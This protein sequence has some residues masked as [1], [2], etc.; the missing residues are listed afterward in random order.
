[1]DPA[2]NLVSCRLKRDLDDLKR[3]LEETQNELNAWKFTPD[4][5]TGK[6][7]M[8]KCRLLYQENE[9]LGK[10]VSAGRVAK[11]EGDLAL[12]KNF[13]AELKKSQSELEEFLSELDEDVEGLQ[14]TIYY[15][16]KQ[17]QETKDQVEQL[18]HDNE[19]LRRTQS[20]QP[21]AANIEELTNGPIAIDPDE[22]I[23]QGEML[24][25][26]DIPKEVEIQ[27]N[28]NIDEG[29]DEV[30]T[31]ESASEGH[32]EE[33][34]ELEEE[35]QVE[36]EEEEETR[37][38][39]SQAIEADDATMDSEE[40]TQSELVSSSRDQSS[41]A[42]ACVEYD[43]EYSQLDTEQPDSSGLKNH[44]HSNNAA[45]YGMRTRSARKRQSNNQDFSVSSS[46]NGHN[47]SNSNK[48]L[49]DGPLPPRTSKRLRYAQDEA[50]QEPDEGQSSS[51]ASLTN[52]LT[53][54][55]G[56][57]DE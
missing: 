57:I 26:E 49:V 42:A 41:H 48:R 29:E 2:V 30:Q 39:S 15:L 45:C 56:S 3:R 52:G 18:I 22:S 43:L 19:A 27:E 36:E 17:L 14:S 44:H 11:L 6:R 13:S 32:G 38:E 7:L 12:Q 46:N 8:A 16:Q 5:N 20:T 34:E 9:E 40:G 33:V 31:Q 23:E 53:Q 24:E 54:D 1:M 51:L 47:S 37:A 35:V 50:N 21:A 4:S 25:P 55:S 28:N 10:M